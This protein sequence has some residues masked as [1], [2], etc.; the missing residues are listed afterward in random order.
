MPKYF[1]V[2]C[3]TC[4]EPIMIGEYE[5]GV[6]VVPDLQP[7]PC[8]ECGSNHTGYGSDDVFPVEESD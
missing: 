2:K 4:E 8:K 5:E 3:Q 6:T 1:A 7:I